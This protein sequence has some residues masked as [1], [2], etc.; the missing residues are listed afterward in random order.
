[1]A[2]SV[3]GAVTARGEWT[4]RGRMIVGMRNWTS[5]EGK[6]VGCVVLDLVRLVHAWPVRLYFLV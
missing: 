4:F 6:R 5:W 3:P 2:A 1:M